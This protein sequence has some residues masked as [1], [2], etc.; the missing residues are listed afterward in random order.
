[1]VPQSNEQR[2]REQ[3]QGRRVL[4]PS[5]IYVARNPVTLW[6]YDPLTGQSVAIGTLVG[7]FP[8]QAVFTLRTEQRAALEVPYTINMDFGLTAISEAVR[9]RMKNAGYTQSVEAYVFQTNDVQPK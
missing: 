4:E 7:E 6:W 2:W 1:M 8:A 9:D 3:Q 5:Q